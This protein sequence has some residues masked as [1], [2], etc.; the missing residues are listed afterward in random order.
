MEDA[1]QMA[2]NRNNNRLTSPLR[3]FILA[4]SLTS[5]SAISGQEMPPGLVKKAAAREAENEAARNNYLYT[6]AV[7]M[8]E[9]NPR[10]GRSG[11]YREVREVMFS[12]TGA[13]TEELVGK[14][15]NSLVRMTLTAEDFRDIRE[16][17]PMLLTTDHLFLYETKFRGEEQMDGIDCWVLQVKPR[18]ILDGQRLFEGMLWIDKSDFSTI[19][20]EGQAVPQI[21][22][23]KQEN[24]FPHFTTVREKVD[25][26]F[27][28]PLKTY[29][30]DTLYFRS[31]PQRVRLIIRYTKYQ[32][33]GAEST[34]T[35][36][37]PK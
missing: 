33:F 35:F 17:Q 36:G 10:G 13:R 11:E 9:F 6:Q 30:D 22:S 27:W 2:I 7:T 31:G 32:R 4:F 3:A 12:P 23:T 24:L 28:F 18:Q 19:R 20:S 5:I 1:V 8:E 14:P 29:A 21:R 15:N 37:E 25:G 34:I 16:V 26:K